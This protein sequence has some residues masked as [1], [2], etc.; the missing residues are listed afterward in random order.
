MV[1]TALRWRSFQANAPQVEA[2]INAAKQI[3]IAFGNVVFFEIS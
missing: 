1:V 3:T 2:A